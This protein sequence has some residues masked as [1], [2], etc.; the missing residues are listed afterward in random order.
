MKKVLSIAIINFVFFIL[1]E[2]LLGGVGN[3]KDFRTYTKFKQPGQY[4]ACDVY[5][6]DS[7]LMKED[8]SSLGTDD[9]SLFDQ[10]SHVE[11]DFLWLTSGWIAW[12]YP[13]EIPMGSDIQSISY[14]V[15]I[16]SEYPGGNWEWPSDIT[17]SMNGID[18]DTWTIPGDPDALYGYGCQENHL[19]SSSSQ[20][21]WLVTWTIDKTG[22]YF[23]YKFRLGDSAKLR[24]SEITI[25]DIGILPR[26]NLRITLSVP[27]RQWG[28]GLNIFG[29][30]WGDYDYD[31]TI[32]IDYSTPIEGRINV[33]P[34]LLSLNSRSR[35]ITVYIEFPEGYDLADIDVNTIRLNG[36][37]SPVYTL[38]I[39]DHDLDEILDMAVIFRRSDVQKIL[40]VGEKV[41]IVIAGALIDGTSFGGF[42]IIE[43]SSNSIDRWS[44]ARQRRVASYN[45][46]IDDTYLSDFSDLYLYFW[47]IARTDG[48]R[49]LINEYCCYL[50]GAI[51]G[52][53]FYYYQ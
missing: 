4:T 12:D 9:I 34:D 22:T 45:D 16:A 30:T 26:E 21:G 52:T 46:M 31:P 11:A 41:G 51:Y 2:I 13:I 29:D 35:W 38:P 36:L 24:V 7:G 17:L 43:V 23:E 18:V 48:I 28:Y 40:E 44:R 33:Y 25:D 15:E 37:V 32:M 49:E 10:P 39:S 6:P 42:D 20:Y 53:F 47:E 1:L 27:Y 8:G 5:G 14:T 19:I 3:A 50:S